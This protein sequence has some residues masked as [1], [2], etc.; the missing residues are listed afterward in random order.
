MEEEFSSSNIKKSIIRSALITLAIILYPIGFISTAITSNKI[1]GST[2]FL[3]ALGI[4]GFS[5]YQSY[6][7]TNP[8]KWLN[9]VFKVLLFLLGLGILIFIL[10]V[11]I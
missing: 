3:I 8:L 2:I 6:Q 5:T 11:N 10:S 4:V 1:I 7:D 9:I